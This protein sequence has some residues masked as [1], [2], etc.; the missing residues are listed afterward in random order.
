MLCVA[1]ALQGVTVPW[2][3]DEV[4]VQ[5][6]PVCIPHVL[7]VDSAAHAVRVP[8]HG[9][10]PALH[11]QPGVVQVLDEVAA[12]QLAIVPVHVVPEYVHPWFA[13]V[14][15]DVRAL[16]G[17]IVPV[18]LPPHV[19]PYEQLAVDVYEE[20][21]VGVPEQV[22][23]VPPSLLQVHPSAVHSDW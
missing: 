21:G 23:P 7:W 16:H 17:V 2:Q 5:R 3:T 10:A 12:P 11:E 18:Q 20:H 6:H 15:D 13:Q 14:E 4:D 1:S 8:V 9:V 19:H 22:P